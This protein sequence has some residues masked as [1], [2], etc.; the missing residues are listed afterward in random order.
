MPIYEY[1]CEKC[2]KEH[3]V[4][5]KM[6]EKPLTVCESCGGRLKKLI[7]NTSFVLKGSG[8]YVTDYA[9]KNL[10]SSANEIADKKEK[11]DSASQKETKKEKKDG[12]TPKETKTETSAGT[13]TKKESKSEQKPSQKSKE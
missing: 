13:E 3:E 6:T 11:I 2:G 8:W 12:T 7:S 4:M 1:K 10:K 5:Q 9:D